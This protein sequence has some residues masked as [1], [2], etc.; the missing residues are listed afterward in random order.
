[1]LRQENPVRVRPPKDLEEWRQHFPEL[2]GVGD[3]EL[4]SIFNLDSINVH[5]MNWAQLA[6]AIY[7]R[8]RDGF[9]GFVVA[10]GTDTMA[11][12]A[13]AVA[14]ALGEHLSFPV[15]FTGAQTTAQVLYGDA[16]TNLARAM[17][18]A[19]QPIPEVV[20]C[21]AD[22]V[23]RA[24]RTHKR[25][26][27]S[28]DAFESPAYPP[29]AHITEFIQVQHELVRK[30]PNQGHDIELRA[31]F[32][33]GILHIVQ[34]PGLEPDLFV[35]TLPS[36]HLC[37]TCGWPASHGAHYCASCGRALGPAAAATR[38]SQPATDSPPELRGI[39]IQT[40]GAGNV[41]T[42]EPYSFLPLIARAVR[43]GIPVLIVGQF[44]AQRATLSQYTPATAPIELGAIWAGDM[45]MPAAV[46]KFRWALARVDAELA[47]GLIR[48]DQRMERVR[49]IVQTP[50]VGELDEGTVKEAVMPPAGV[51][52]TTE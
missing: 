40:P 12:T 28:F 24:T 48:A 44:P 10:H 17:A 52:A 45:T 30:P 39:V 8:R 25:A 5:P 31:T 4:A 37:S 41:S 6:V 3:V 20:I 34:V 36:G 15:V 32:A 42:V 2:A 16:R 38:H 1:M 50:V 49:Q 35:R 19:L 9:D 14:F 13:S 47:E 27:L 51:G 18:V 29:I 33:T 43:G 46:V 21:F 23:F 11:F 26:E 22:R 7:R